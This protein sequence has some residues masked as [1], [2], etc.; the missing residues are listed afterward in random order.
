MPLWNLDL[1]ISRHARRSHRTGP[2]AAAAVITEGRDALAAR[3]AA[4]LYSKTAVTLELTLQS[5]AFLAL[6]AEFT[7]GTLGG[8]LRG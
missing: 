8:E 6:F 1:D 7:L 3:N 4:S 5:E 2:S